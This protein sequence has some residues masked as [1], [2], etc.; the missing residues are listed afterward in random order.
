MAL[1][2]AE[3]TSGSAVAETDYVFPLSFAQQRLWFLHQLEPGN[4]FYNLPLAVPFNVAVNAAVLK[5]SINEI[6]NRH[7]TL[8]TVFDAIDGEPKQIVRPSL[9]VPLEVIDLGALSKDEQTAETTRLTAEMAQRPFDLA[10]GPLLRTALLRRGV[11]DHVFV[12]VMHHIIS[13]GWSLGVFWRELIVVYNAFYMSLPSPLEELPIQYADFAVWQRERL[14]GDRL[15][16]LSTYWHKKLDGLPTLQLPVDRPRP[17]MLSYRGAF[18]ELALPR[19]LTGAL[20]LLS[21]REGVTLFMTLLA[22]FAVLLQRYSGQDDIVIGLPSASRDRKELE[23]LIGFFIN[24]LVLRVDLSDDPSFRDLLAR[25]RELA[26]DA[27]AHQELPFEKLVEQLQPE[28]DLSRNPLFQVSFQL[29]SAPGERSRGIQSADAPPIVVNR[30]SAIFDLAVNL[31]EATDEIGGNLEYSTD[32]FDAS[33]IA[34][35]A[36]HFRTLLR[37]ASANPDAKLS[38]LQL[39][40]DAEQ[41]QILVEWNDTLAAV[42]Q[43]CVHELFEQWASQIPDALA[44][45]EGEKTLS[46]GDLNRRANRLAHRLHALGVGPGKLVCLCVE[47]GTSMVVGLLAILKA[48]GAYVPLDPG[49]PPDR[50][51]T[52]LEDS[53][54]SIVLSELSTSTHLNIKAASLVLLDDNANFDGYDDTNLGCRVSPDDLCYVIYTSGST[55]KP[56]GVSIPHRGLMNLV[57]WHRE[58]FGISPAD[59]AS[60]VASVAFDACGW[61]LWPYLAAGASVHIVSDEIRTSSRELIKALIEKKITI[62]FLPTPLAQ[63]VLEDPAH[64]G[65]Q[66]RYLLIGGDTLT[67]AVPPG[68][69]FITVNNYGPTEYSV[70]ATS[71]AL[72]TDHGL[73]PSIGR[74]IANTRIFVLDRHRNPAPIG[75]VG[76]LYVGGEGLARGYHNRP[77]LTAEAFI[78]SPIPGDA[79]KKLYKTGDLVRYRSDGM[80]EYLGRTDAQIKIRGFRIE[81]GEIEVA[82]AEHKDVSDAIVTVVTR[83]G[84]SNRLVAYVVPRQKS[85]LNGNGSAVSARQELIDALRTHLRARLPDYMMPAHFI[86]LAQLPQTQNGKIDRHALP[87]L[88]GA[89]DREEKVVVAP[90]SAIE[91]VLVGAWGEVLDIEAVG[92]DDN[93]FEIGGHSLLAARLI[94]R[95]RDRLKVEVP[96]QTLFRSPTPAGFAASLINSSADPAAIERIAK[97]VTSLSKLTDQEVKTILTRG[98]L[99]TDHEVRT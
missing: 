94:S 85:A 91:E 43:S 1:T 72:G 64:V 48:G 12:L 18:Q 57:A 83:A 7:E 51:A 89:R 16:E 78:D 99:T 75:V 58:A 62:G 41:Q 8:R 17:P 55:G 59:R 70:V 27:Y 26:L 37:S 35:L 14:Q 24:S 69:D 90:R 11:Q 46:Y 30:G 68:N 87:S 29:F 63:M 76:E 93:F 98:A 79:G 71:C 47:R 52:M 92:I 38:R 88:A 23:G 31:W 15:L 49:Y 96:L 32:L 50:L 42:P 66:L 67:R 13:D 45:A 40:S 19:V 81:L 60:Q 33:T 84:E 3:T 39:L 61:E 21:H 77:D 9:A 28:R 10:Q 5:R 97:L 65:L 73:K 53:D 44:V 95:V 34:R 80:L 25:V 6:V 82:L 86:V 36:S 22:A 20:K 74:P 2:G 56:K 4:T 54:A